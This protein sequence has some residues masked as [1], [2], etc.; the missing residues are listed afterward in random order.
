MKSQE[1]TEK[2]GLSAAKGF[3]FWRHN[4]V[5]PKRTKDVV[6]CQEDF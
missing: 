1:P 2:H 3:G 5:G 4:P 6:Y